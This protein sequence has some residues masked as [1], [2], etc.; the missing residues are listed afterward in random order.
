MNYC[1]DGVPGLPSLQIRQQNS[2]AL[3]AVFFCLLKILQQSERPLLVSMGSGKGGCNSWGSW[4]RVSDSV[5]ALWKAGKLSAY[6]CLYRSKQFNFFVGNT[7]RSLC[8]P[9]LSS[10]LQTFVFQI[11]NHMFLGEEVG[12]DHSGYITAPSAHRLVE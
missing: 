2:V 9:E 8:I 1:S 6:L 11:Q 3:L 4:G 7:H 5:A 10:N 12:V